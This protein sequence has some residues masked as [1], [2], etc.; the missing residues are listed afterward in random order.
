M[1][2]LYLAKKDYALAIESAKISLQHDNSYTNH[3]LLVKA[4]WL[5]KQFSQAFMQ[6]EN[7][8]GHHNDHWQG[9]RMFANLLEQRDESQKAIYWYRETLKL[10]PNDVFS[11]NNLALL[12]L[13]NNNSS[14]GLELIE[15]AS[16]LAPL[17]A[18]VN[19]TYGWIL[20]NL[21]EYEE[22]L[23]YLRESYARDVNNAKTM[24]HIGFTLDKLAKYQESQYMLKQALNKTQD[25]ELLS[26]IQL[27]LDKS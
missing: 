3:V 1:A 20:V 27:L 11:L 24:Y 12:L 13:G 22:G 2:N 17:D 18:K 6:F 19:D 15:Q 16:L 5:N 26:L 23:K 21:Q 10:A 14:E 9:K 8:L 25:K 4:Y 7:W